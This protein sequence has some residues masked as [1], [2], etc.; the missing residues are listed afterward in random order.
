[1]NDKNP[2]IA[3]GKKLKNIASLLLK[4]IEG[5]PSTSTL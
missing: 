1:M 5:D 2:F 4:G 3:D